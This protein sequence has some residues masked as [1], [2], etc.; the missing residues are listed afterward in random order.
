MY[1]FGFIVAATLGCTAGSIDLT[2]GMFRHL[3]VTGRSRLALYLAR[4]P[5]G[6]AIV[7]PFVAVG[8][9]IICTVCVFAAPTSL[10]YDGANLPAGLSRAGLESWAAGHPEEVICDFSYRGPI[11]RHPVR[12]RRPRRQRPGTGDPAP[13]AWR[14]AVRRVG[15]T[16]HAGTGPGRGRRDRPAELLRLLAELPHPSVSLM[17]RSGLWVELEATIGFIV[18]PG[19]RLA[20]RTADGGGDPDDRARGHPDSDHLA[21]A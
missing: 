19:A 3:V 12:P 20:A 5:A 8:F 16:G 11:R 17:V 13:T 2:E 10:N 4:I 21:G 9:A 7:V 6:L 1:V 18:G 15:A 14:A